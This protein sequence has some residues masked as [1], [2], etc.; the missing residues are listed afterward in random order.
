MTDF[1][2]LVPKGGLCGAEIS[3]V[4]NQTWVMAGNK[5]S[6]FEDSGVPHECSTHSPPARIWKWDPLEVT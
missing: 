2:S 1:M 5:P 4:Q 6:L 3:A